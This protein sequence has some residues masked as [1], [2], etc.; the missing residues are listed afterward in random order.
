MKITDESFPWFLPL[1]VAIL[2]VLITAALDS[3]LK[4]MLGEQQ[5]VFLGLDHLVYDEQITA[6]FTA[7]SEAKYS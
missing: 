3:G 1:K 7:L 6:W 5:P 4:W 2:F